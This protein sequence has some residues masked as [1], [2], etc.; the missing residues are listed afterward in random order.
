M[1][2]LVQESSFMIFRKRILVFLMRNSLLLVQLFGLDEAE[3]QRVISFLLYYGIIGVQRASEDEPLYIYDVN[4]NIEVLRVRIRK[5]QNATRYI[6]NP[7]L[8][9]AL[10]VYGENDVAHL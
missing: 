8:W 1:F 5:W 2:F 4:Y 6:V 7:A 9:P 3:S 10:N